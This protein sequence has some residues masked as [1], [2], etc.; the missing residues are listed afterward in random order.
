MSYDNLGAS[1]IIPELRTTFLIT[2]PH[3]MTLSPHAVTAAVFHQMYFNSIS[4]KVGRNR[5]GIAP[6]LEES[7][8]TFLLHAKLKEAGAYLMFPKTIFLACFICSWRDRV[9]FGPECS[10]DCYRTAAGA[11]QLKKQ[12]SE[13][14]DRPINVIRQIHLGLVV[15]AW[16]SFSSFSPDLISKHRNM[17]SV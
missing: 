10:P 5:Y 17:R 8:T 6:F 13:W 3:R 2:S 4:V 14:L 16:V 11:K 1:A 9:K 15:D 12:L 7:M